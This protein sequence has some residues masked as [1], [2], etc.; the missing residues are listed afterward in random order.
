MPWPSVTRIAALYLDE[1]LRPRDVTW[2]RDVVEV[3]LGVVTEAHR[4]LNDLI[5]EDRRV[6][7]RQSDGG[8]PRV[9]HVARNAV[10]P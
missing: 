5:T 7:N 8:G 4:K 10:L 1:H 6:W 3:L 2:I 9:R